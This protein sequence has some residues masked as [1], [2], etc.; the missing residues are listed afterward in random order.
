MSGFLCRVFYQEDICAHVN[1]TVEAVM[2]AFLALCE[3]LIC[4]SSFAALSR[5]SDHDECAVSHLILE[6]IF[7]A[8]ITM[9]AC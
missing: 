5:M 6:T 2:C 9:L 3:T 4:K 8:R 1:G 7:F